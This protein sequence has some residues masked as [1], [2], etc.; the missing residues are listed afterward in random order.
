MNGLILWWWTHFNQWTINNTV[1]YNNVWY[2]TVFYNTG[3]ISIEVHSISGTVGY[4]LFVIK[5]NYLYYLDF[6]HIYSWNDRSKCYQIKTELSNLNK[7]LK[8]VV[9]YWRN[10]KKLL[11]TI[12][13]L[14]LVENI[15]W[16][17][18]LCNF[19]RIYIF[20]YGASLYLG[21]F[22]L[23]S[24]CLSQLFIICNSLLLY[25]GQAEAR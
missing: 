20:S 4:L 18:F 5:F 25:P 3:I 19:P 24:F 2:N 8:T 6:A 23:P 15:S 11:S 22:V 12:L 9:K 17:H 21:L 1:L 14:F 7:W 10:N 13:N 16:V